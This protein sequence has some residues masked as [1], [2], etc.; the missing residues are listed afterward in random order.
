LKFKVDDE[1]GK[2][3]AYEGSGTATFVHLQG[4]VLFL[5]VHAEKS[6]LQWCRDESRRWA[7]AIIAANPSTGEIA[8]REKRSSRSGF[9]WNKVLTNGLIGAVIGGIVGGL[10]ALRKRKQRKAGQRK[11]R[12]LESDFSRQERRAP[13]TEG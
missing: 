1:N 3:T 5:Y 10:N 6:A 9:N 12:W 8:A 4:K 2:P 11:N 7:D 13:G